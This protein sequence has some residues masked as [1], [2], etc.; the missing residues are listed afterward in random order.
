[1]GTSS[2]NYG[3]VIEIEA[4]DNSD[5]LG[6][7]TSDEKELSTVVTPKLYKYR[8]YELFV[9]SLIML[10]IGC[11]WICFSPIFDLLQDVYGVSLFTV[12]YLSLSYMVFFIPVNFPS[13][14]VLEKYGLRFGV[15][16]G[17]FLSVIGLWVRCLINK[18]FMYVII[19]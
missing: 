12:N 18:S 16:F 8:F 13:T 15:L 2:K 11:A 6:A 19:G 3:E 4:L 1:V 14:I 7:S 10:T 5:L 9:F 17:F